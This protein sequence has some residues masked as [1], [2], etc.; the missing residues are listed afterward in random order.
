MPFI[1]GCLALG[2]PRVMLFLVWA[3]SDL[4]EANIDNML[5]AVAGLVFAP[6]TT[7]AYAYGHSESGGTPAGIWPVIL[8][9]AVLL[10]MGLLRS[11]RSKKEKK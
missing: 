8:V 2:M 11:S 7:L 3:F 6:L 5:W 10:D 1:V 9:L 4:L